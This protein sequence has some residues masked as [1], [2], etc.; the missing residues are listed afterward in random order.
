MSPIKFVIGAQVWQY[1]ICTESARW[2]ASLTFSRKSLQA[3]ARKVVHWLCEIVLRGLALHHAD[4][5]FQNTELFPLI[6]AP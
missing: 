4:P 1:K 5:S 2:E 6:S 3:L